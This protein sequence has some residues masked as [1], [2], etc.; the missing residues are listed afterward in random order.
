[1]GEMGIK[2]G[3]QNIDV[4]KVGLEMVLVSSISPTLLHVI[5][6]AIQSYPIVQI[7]EQSSFKFHQGRNKTQACP[8]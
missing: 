4:T 7:F 6:N 8:N 5:S 2:V 1:M 3:M